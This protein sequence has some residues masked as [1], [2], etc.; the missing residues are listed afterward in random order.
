MSPPPPL[1]H[2][3]V[4]DPTVEETV[5]NWLSKSSKAH[6]TFKSSNLFCRDAAREN[7]F[8]NDF[9]DTTFDDDDDEVGTSS[10]S[11]LARGRHPLPSTIVH[12]MASLNPSSFSRTSL[13]GTTVGE[14]VDIVGIKELG[15]IH[16]DEVGEINEVGVEAIDK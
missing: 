7:V 5:G 12:L 4:Q 10:S 3:D 9:D 13:G 14:E 2:E 16:D 6:A 8:D 11:F 15:E 1:Q